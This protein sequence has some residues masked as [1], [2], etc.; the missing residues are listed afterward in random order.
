MLVVALVIRRRDEVL[1]IQESHPG[2]PWYLPAGRVEAGESLIEAA[3]RE[4]REE[5]GVDVEVTR[6]LAVQHRWDGQRPW[7]RF[8]FG[9]IVDDA[10][11]LKR[12][13]DGHSRQ[14][15]WARLDTLASMNLRGP[16]LI[17][18]ARLGDG[19][20]LG[21]DY[22]TTETVLRALGRSAVRPS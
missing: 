17:E 1:L 9:G 5:A 4:C 14:A 11:P 3:R 15:A 13:P 10:S 21:I 18:L 19:E 2:E 20:G 22:V 8:V 7:T 16:D 12:V 6:L